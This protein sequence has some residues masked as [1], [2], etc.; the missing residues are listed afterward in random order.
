MLPNIQ[1]KKRG[2]HRSEH[3]TT[4][5]QKFKGQTKLE[6]VS[7][8]E[9]PQTLGLL[10]ILVGGPAIGDQAAAPTRTIAH[11]PHGNYSSIE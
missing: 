3:P 8:G 9:L 4:R 7:A 6:V 10:Q 2:A 1:S 5:L 11:C